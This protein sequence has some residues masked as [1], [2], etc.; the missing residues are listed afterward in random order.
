MHY[1]RLLKPPQHMR[2]ILVQIPDL[3]LQSGFPFYLT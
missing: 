1:V 2:E 3:K